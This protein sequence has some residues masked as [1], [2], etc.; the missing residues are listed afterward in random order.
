MT[1]GR[2]GASSKVAR[3]RVDR[4]DAELLNLLVLAVG[5]NGGITLTEQLGDSQQIK[6]MTL[7]CLP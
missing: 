4:Q 3:G 1:A 7:G 6:F 5:G 2:P